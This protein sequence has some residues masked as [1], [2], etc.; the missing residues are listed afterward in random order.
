VILPPVAFAAEV[1]DPPTGKVSTPRA[2][3]TV[4]AATGDMLSSKNSGWP[5]SATEQPK[6]ASN[7]PAQNNSLDIGFP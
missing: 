2:P 4:E 3:A 5:P 6:H 7:N 1:G